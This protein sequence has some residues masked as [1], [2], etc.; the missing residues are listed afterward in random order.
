LTIDG[1]LPE[2]VINELLCQ[3]F[4]RHAHQVKM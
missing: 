4:I 1:A 3:D 2:Q